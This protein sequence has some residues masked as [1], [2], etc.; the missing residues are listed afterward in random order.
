MDRKLQELTRQLREE[1]CPPRVLQRVA[2]RVSRGKAPALSWRASLAWTVSIACLL[3]AVALWQVRANREAQRAAAELAA[4]QV[5]ARRA[6]VAQ[7]ALEAFGRVGQA[8]LRVA[9]RT[10][11]TLLKEAAPPLRNGF[12]TAKSKVINPLKT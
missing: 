1:K 2:Q 7:Q 5:R 9:A 8:L 3:G 12:E 11:N 4:A 6:L 10:E